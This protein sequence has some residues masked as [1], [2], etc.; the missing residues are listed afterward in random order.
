MN[1]QTSSE[2]TV[3]ALDLVRL[4]RLA[5]QGGHDALRAELDAADVRRPQDMPP[6]VVTMRSVLDYVEHG[7]DARQRI[8]L[9]YPADADPAAGKVSVMSPLGASLLG[10]RVGESVHWRTPDGTARRCTVAAL[11]WQPE[12]AGEFTL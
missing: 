7:S 9:C 4:S 1:A 2:R 11:A 12:A 6:D 5:A 3:S 10:R 8:T